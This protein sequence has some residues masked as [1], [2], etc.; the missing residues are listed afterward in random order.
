MLKTLGKTTWDKIKIGEVFAVKWCW[1]IA[2]KRSKNMEDSKLLCS[3][4]H[5]Y[6]NQDE[7]DCP[8]GLYF[9][10]L[11]LYKLPKSVQRLWANY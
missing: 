10:G 11:R 6:Q 3:S 5:C 4:H 8:Y 7:W 9:E 1:I 2:L